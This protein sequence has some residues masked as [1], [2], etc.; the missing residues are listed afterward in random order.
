MTEYYYDRLPGAGKSFYRQI[1]SAVSD[2]KNAVTGSPFLSEAVFRETV[3]AVNYDHPELF[4]VNFQSQSFLHDIRGFTLQLGYLYPQTVTQQIKK[5]IDLCI[6][7]IIEEAKACPEKPAYLRYRLLHNRLLKMTAYDFNALSEPAANIEA[8][9]IAGAFCNHSSV[10]EG[11]SKAFKF[12]CDRLELYCIVVTGKSFFAQA[13]S[14]V[15]HAWNIV[16]VED[17]FAHIDV[18]WD[19]NFSTQ[20]RANRYDYFCIGDEDAAVDHVYT[21]VPVC[22]SKKFTYF[23]LQN[24][25]IPGYQALEMFLQAKLSAQE[26]TL[27]FKLTGSSKTTKKTIPKITEAVEKVAA[28]YCPNGYSLSG[29]FNE[30]QFIFFYRVTAL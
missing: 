28:K 19:I 17:G 6:A 5:Q 25:A 2:R 3:Q 13:G 26:K 9:T 22:N 1:L 18:T 20:S 7:P 27:Y 14:S 11:I 16:R 24:A 4:Y 8:Y 30:N 29:V 23:S 15:D 12:L 21:G 10:C